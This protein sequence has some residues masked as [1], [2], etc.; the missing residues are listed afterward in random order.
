M[1]CNCCGT[2]VPRNGKPQD[3]DRDT[4]FGWCLSCKPIAIA[5]WMKDDGNV[6]DKK[7]SAE[8][9]EARWQKYYG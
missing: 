9:A 3:P 5:D 6:S 7:L 2:Y 8:K 4:G 1:I